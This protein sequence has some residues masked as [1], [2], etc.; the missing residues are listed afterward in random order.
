M[1]TL[2]IFNSVARKGDAEHRAYLT[3]Q[4]AT[5]PLTGAQYQVKAIQKRNTDD[6]FGIA[7]YLLEINV[8]ACAVGNNFL[9]VNDMGFACQF[10][11]L[12]LQHWLLSN[13][14]HA[15][16][17]LAFSL[18][19]A[20]LVGATPTFLV[21]FSTK[22]EALKGLNELHQH[23]R[24]VNNLRLRKKPLAKLPV[25]VVGDPLELTFYI[26]HEHYNIRAYQKQKP[27]QK[28]FAKFTGLHKEQIQLALSK[29][30]SKYVRLEVD[31]SQKWLLKNQ[32]DNPLN[33]TQRGLS[34]YELAFSVIKQALWASFKF[35]RRL[36]RLSDYPPEGSVDRQ[37][38]EAYFAGLNVREHPLICQNKNPDKYF[39][40]LN[41]RIR[42]RLHIDY[43]IP[44]ADCK[45]HLSHRLDQLLA[46]KVQ[47]IPPADFA[48]SIFGP[49]TMP[50]V[51]AE[52]QGCIDRLVLT[53]QTRT[54]TQN[55][56]QTQPQTQNIVDDNDTSD[57][58][59]LMG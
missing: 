18:K 39:H 3:P 35:R 43:R 53:A 2:P 10:A 37:L 4:T 48:Q 45:Q 27:I 55:Q 14:C 6:V 51:I 24:T 57:I 29:E 25:C 9:L 33:W 58:S 22:E 47:F 19:K 31:L 50:G 26:Q 28:G 20:K 12:L 59:D 42:Q 40:D 56:P 49:L 46:A 44:W 17:V 38:C 34:A 36:P 52:L 7:G 21:P 5:S 23:A 15:D 41:E 13:G 8:P 1:A 11:L 16:A 32:L 54:R 30:A